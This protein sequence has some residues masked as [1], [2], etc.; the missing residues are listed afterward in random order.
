MSRL[1]A[2]AL[3]AV[4]VMAPMTARAAPMAQTLPEPAIPQATLASDWKVTSVSGPSGPHEV[5][6][7]ELEHKNQAIFGGILIGKA[8]DSIE[9]QA[10]VESAK[11]E[12]QSG[13]F[14]LSP[15]QGG[16]GDGSA[17]RGIAKQLLPGYDVRLTIVTS[18]A[19]AGPRFT[20]VSTSGIEIPEQTLYDLNSRLV[21]QQIDRF[22]ALTPQPTPAPSPVATPTPAARP[23]D[24][25]ALILPP[26]DLGSNWVTTDTS[27]DAQSYMAEYFNGT[28]DY[29]GFGL[30]RL[31][32]EP[33]SDS[34]AGRRAHSV[35]ARRP[36]RPATDRRRVEWSG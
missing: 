36:G 35:V 24:P 7:I 10:L 33:L 29:A 26:A 28:V 22:R 32:V 9:A 11:A 17:Y 27:S 1:L 31:V 3:L 14:T 5:F 25:K 20:Q 18:I 8:E 12:I 2:L 15:V 16:P 13:G 21:A 30:D 23:L 4:L 34:A 6:T 19:R